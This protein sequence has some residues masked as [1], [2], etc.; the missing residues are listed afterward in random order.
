MAGRRRRQGLAKALPTPSSRP[1]AAI[2]YVEYAY[3]KQNNLSYTKMLNAAGK[4]VEPS[5]ESFAA[6]AFE[7]RLRQR[8][9]LQPD[10]HQPAGRHHL[11]D[12]GLHLGADPQAQPDDAAAT[13]EALKFFAWAYK[14]GKD[15]AKALDYV[16]IPDSVV[17]LIE[18]SWSADHRP[19]ASRSTPASK[20]SL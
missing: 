16:A 13:G 20:P 6:A 3:A 11:A 18:S 1:P 19:T 7:C 2:G 17:A 5:L 10:H 12:R 4:I 14:D 15:Q 9:E 8:Q